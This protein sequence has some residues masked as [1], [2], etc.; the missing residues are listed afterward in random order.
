MK[1]LIALYLVILSLWSC[2]DGN[3]DIEEFD[4]SNAVGAACVE[5]NFFYKINGSEVLLLQLQSPAFINEITPI[6]EPRTINISSSNSVRYRVYSDVMT[7]ALLCSNIAP[8]TPVVVEEWLASSGTIQIQ[9]VVNK[10]TNASTGATTITGYTHNVNLLDVTFIKGDGNEQLFTNLNIGSFVTADSTPATFGIG[11]ARCNNSLDF[12]YKI[13]STSAR[14]ALT[15][16]LDPDTFFINEATAA[17][18]PRTAV[19]NGEDVTLRYIA[20]DGV[21]NQAYF[22]AATTPALPVPTIWECIQ[23]TIEV[24]TT[25]VNNT[26]THNIRLKNTVFNRNNV[27]FSLGTDYDFGNIIITP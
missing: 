23:G 21:V 7:N 12:M 16:H 19:I 8:A 15:L 5:G 17:D 4:F 2:D 24:H 10:T 11:I 18:A 22:C 14:Q 3:F 1:K 6:N 25:E 9:T 27:D 13:A 26:Y 20:Y